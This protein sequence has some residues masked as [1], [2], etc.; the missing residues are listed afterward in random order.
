YAKLLFSNLIN[1]FGDSIDAIAFTWLVYDITKSASWA[2]LM[3]GLNVLPNVVLQ[4]FLGAY[5]EKLDKKKVVVLTHVL[6]TILISLFVVLYLTKIVNPFIMAAFTILITTIESLNLP[7]STA[8]IQNLIKKEEMSYAISLNSSLSNAVALVGTGMAGVIIATIGVSGAMFIDAAT[9]LIAALAILAIKLPAKE[10]L[11]SA[12]HEETSMNNEA[13]PVEETTV[14]T[15]T[16]ADKGSKQKEDSYFFLLKD[17]FKYVLKN[18]IIVNICIVAVMINFLG[19]PLNALEAPIASE[20]FKLGSELL[21][22]MGMAASIGAIIGSLLV[23]MIIEKFSTKKIIVGSGFVLGVSMFALS[24]GKYLDGAAIPGYLLAGGCYF[25]LMLACSIVNSAISVQFLKTT[26]P[27]Y[28]S[29]AAA[30]LGAS[31]SMAMPIASLLVSALTL[32]FTADV[33][34]AVSGISAV[35]L[36]IGVAVSKMKFDSETVAEPEPKE[37]KA[38]A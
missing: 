22:I 16:V 12:T 25:F 1:R 15:S 37:A 6:R 20:T 19:V 17:G 5:V 2:A 18:K 3:Y 26:D 13:S 34:I 4:P 27:K 10:T 36:I 33:L 30:V 11:V 21:S 38:A 29:R 7:A 24:L 35:L 23:P 32:H 9:F 28:I 8:F 14:V 31:C